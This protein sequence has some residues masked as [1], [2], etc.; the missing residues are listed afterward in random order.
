MS[1]R[2]LDCILAEP[3]EVCQRRWKHCFSNFVNNIQKECYHLVLG[4]L[5]MCLLLCM[6]WWILRKLVKKYMCILPLFFSKKGWCQPFYWDSMHS[7]RSLSLWIPI[8][9]VQIFVFLVVLTWCKTFVSLT[10][11]SKME[12]GRP[13]HP[14]A[15]TVGGELLD[16]DHSHGWQ[17][18]AT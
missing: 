7:C 13:R 10:L 11:P 17:N 1:K 12:V 16:G 18:L 8:A 3:E 6:Q 9:P 15:S 2:Y 5:Q 14:G 4:S